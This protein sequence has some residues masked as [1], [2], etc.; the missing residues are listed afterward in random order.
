V[1]VGTRFELSSPA[2][3]TKIGG[4][5]VGHPENTDN[6][7]FG[8]VV[9]IEHESDFPDSGDLSSSDVLGT[10]LLKFP[11]QSDEV[12]GE[13][14]ITLEPGWYAVVFGSGLFGT[15]AVGGAVRNGIDILSPTYIGWQPATTGWFELDD[16]FDNHR[17]VVEGQFTPEPSTVSVAAISILLFLF[18][19]FCRRVRSR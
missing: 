13:L 16:F 14:S 9:R 8:A 2:L 1:F 17:F 3:T 5:F 12:F 10:A 19:S 18:H 7:F 11:Q 6:D 15:T 4:H